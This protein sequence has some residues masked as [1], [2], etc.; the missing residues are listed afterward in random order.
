MSQLQPKA[1]SHLAERYEAADRAS[2]ECHYI[3]N[4]KI[5]QS[6]G[7]HW[8]LPPVDPAAAQWLLLV[9]LL[10]AGATNETGTA[11]PSRQGYVVKAW[12]K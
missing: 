3:I 8:G 4:H 12:E 7:I 9:V 11:L 2:A 5:R 1:P 6:R 10:S